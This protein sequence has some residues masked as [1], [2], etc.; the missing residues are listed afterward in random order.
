MGKVFNVTGACNPKYHY[1]V[2]IE[3]RL[4]DIKQLVDAGNYFAINRARQY[5]KTTTLSEWCAQSRQ[6]I[7]L[8]IDEVD[9]AS[10][11]QVFL[12][13]LAQFR[14]YFLAR[15]TKGRATFQSVIL[16]GV[17]NIK[18]LKLKVNP[19]TE[20]KLNSPWNIA[21]DFTLDMSFNQ[22]GITGMLQE[23]EADHHTGMDIDGMAQL[24][25]VPVT[26]ILRLEPGTWNVLM[27]LWITVENNLLL[28]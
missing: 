21:T 10:N 17:Y 5:G 18:N 22:Y 27:L 9:S 3:Q 26:I 16:A 14:G 25:M 8:M 28:R 19:D 11:N 13:F 6:V 1:M 23:Y 15:T 4:Q 12:D 20:H 2:N 24:L 7:V